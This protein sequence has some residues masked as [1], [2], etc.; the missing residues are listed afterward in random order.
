[1]T[2]GSYIATI[3][4]EIPLERRVIDSE[5]LTFKIAELSTNQLGMTIAPKPPGVIHPILEWDVVKRQNGH[6]V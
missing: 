2:I 3:D 6:L 4:F 5:S 1:M